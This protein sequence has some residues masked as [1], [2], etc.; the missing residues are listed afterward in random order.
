MEIHQMNWRRIIVAAIWSELLVW[1][2]YIPSLRYAL[3]YEGSAAAVITPL[4]MFLPLFLGGL[5]IARKIESRFVLHGVLAAIL[6][7]VLYL[8]LMPTL[9]LP[10]LLGDPFVSQSRQM[11]QQVILTVTFICV[12]LRILGAA[13]GAWIGGKRRRKFPSK[14]A[15]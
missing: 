8:L 9:L 13:T 15:E 3:R 7:N 12:V 4:Q 14:K 2:L 6:A 1:A 5:W 10:L 11:D